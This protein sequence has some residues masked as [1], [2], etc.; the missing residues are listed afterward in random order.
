MPP[1][2]ENPTLAQDPP[3]QT[4]SVEEVRAALGQ[5][6]PDGTAP[7]AASQA[8]PPAPQGEAAPA[9]TEQPEQEAPQVELPDGWDSHEEVA[10]KLRE[11]E[12][13][14]YNKAKSHLTRAHTAAQAEAEET[15]K[16]EI[17]Q[18]SQQAL[19]NAVVQSLADKIQEFDLGDPETVTGLRKALAGTGQWANVFMQAQTTEAQRS[20]I[21]QITS[22]GRLTQDFPEETADE[23]N[24]YVSELGLKLRGRVARAQTNEEVGKAYSEALTDYLTE[25]DKLRDEIIIAQALSGKGKELEGAAKKAAG[26]TERADNR[27]TTSPPAR[28]TGAGGRG[29]LTVEQELADPKTPVKRLE[30]IRAKQR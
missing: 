7:T 23:F 28:P 6:G 20:L 24:A 21:Y 27:Q 12:S 25:R 5:P 3:T 13:A 4:E 22:N 19:A 29:G 30:E 17:Q 1:A 8:E 15:Y 11:A 10:A 14:G 16:A 9:S 2:T 18:V 26:L